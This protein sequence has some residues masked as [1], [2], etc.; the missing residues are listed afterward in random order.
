MIQTTVFEMYFILLG[1]IALCDDGDFKMELFG[2]AGETGMFKVSLNDMNSEDYE[3][4][5][6]YDKKN[7]NVILLLKSN[8]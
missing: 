1:S 3:M 8:N 5:E 7:K 2:T 6:N 4:K